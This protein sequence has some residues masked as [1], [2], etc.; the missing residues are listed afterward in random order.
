MSS[1]LADVYYMCC[2]IVYGFVLGR[3]TQSN[4]DALALLWASL[5]S[6]MVLALF[7]ACRDA[8]VGFG[9]HACTLAACPLAIRSE[10][11]ECKMIA[12]VLA[13]AH[14]FVILHRMSRARCTI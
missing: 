7:H 10:S 13:C 1:K 11:A 9:I 2:V 8:Y 12:L 4:A 3:L 14:T 5:S 6:F